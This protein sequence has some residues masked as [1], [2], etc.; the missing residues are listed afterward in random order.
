VARR[1]TFARLLSRALPPSLRR[2][3]P[4]TR[5]RA[6]LCIAYT[7]VTLPVGLVAAALCWS[8]GLYLVSAM[9]TFYAVVGILPVLTLRRTASLG[10]AGNM[11]TGLTAVVAISCCWLTGGLR[12]AGLVWLA[13]P[14]ALAVLLVDRRSGIGWA[15]VS[16]L[17]A[18]GLLGL[19]QL[20]VVGPF[21]LEGQAL[22]ISR[23]INLVGLTSVLVIFAGLFESFKNRALRSLERVNRA[24]V[25]ARDEAEAATRAK[26]EFLANMSHE[27][28]TPLNG[29]IG[30]AALLGDTGLTREQREYADTIR[31]SGDVLL[32]L[33]GDILDWSKIEAGSTDLEAAPFDC[34]ALVE[35]A[36]ALMAEPA[37][38]KGIEIVCD[39][40]PDVPTRVVGDGGRLR[41]V[42]L[43]LI[44]NAVKFTAA[45][46]VRVD[47]TCEK[48]PG[49]ASRLR[50][51]VHD[52][53]IGIAPET[54]ARLFQPFTQADASTTRRYGGTGLGLALCKHLIE[55]MG[56]DIGCRSTVGRGSTFWF[57]L[58]FRAADAAGAAAPAPPL[59]HARVL[60][61]DD[62][63]A[64]RGH[65]ATELAALG[66]HAD[67]VANAAEAVARVR[68]ASAE[69][70]S[71][72]LL[73]AT[74]PDLKPPLAAAAI[75]AAA[76]PAQPAIVVL[77]VWTGQQPTVTD[78][79]VLR[80]PVRR[81]AL[82]AAVAEALGGSATPAV[83]SVE[84]P[85]AP[86]AAPLGRVLLVEDNPVNQLVARRMLER[87]GYHVDGAA[88]G[89]AALEALA[90]ADYDIV[91]MDCHL[92][93][94]DG[95]AATRE[96]RR[97]EAGRHTPVIAMTA[98]VTAED[99]DRCL[100][101]GM[102][103][104]LAKPLAQADLATAVARWN[105]GATGDVGGPRL[106]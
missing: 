60:V 56:G 99:R 19:D 47:A 66:L 90:R 87:L 21:G 106:D 41:Q 55:L 35:D 24:L 32:G 68:D 83:A 11:T 61:V 39:V 33:L 95:L 52:T 91:L 92:P 93:E 70:Y 46:E 17:A 72:V 51:A 77:G 65:L 84:P 28:R 96:L 71:L 101:A 34:V 79:P 29:I 9:V 82:R 58:P 100:A 102:D 7:M 13:C 50:F 38:R 16:G 14:P 44:G 104:F 25:E 54:R 85:A 1:R 26:G 5:A 97:R 10:L 6:G 4:D 45:G 18:I 42:L 74:L 43:N 30:M 62:S 86:A 37:H 8:A 69:P 98:G 36:V 78:A 2:A 20:G 94:M 105:R 75:R 27:I 103:D 80:K 48:D 67:T 63:A 49:A 15:T 59:P 88:D 3:D 12:S 31:S 22:E 23:V 53:G 40:A 73:D 64:Q 76:G 57:T 89:R 81:D